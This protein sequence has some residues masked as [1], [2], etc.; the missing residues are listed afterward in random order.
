M[1]SRIL[2]YNSGGGIGD[3]LQILPL[4]N[5]LRNEFKNADFYYLCA[6]ENHFNSS[7]K[8]LNRH[9][10]TL[11][12]NIK[13]FGFRWWHFLILKERI[14]KYK[15]NKFDLIIDLQSKIR[16][17]LILK[18]IP[19]K[20]FISSCFNF[21]FSNP[22]LNIKKVNKIND[23]ILLAVNSILNTNCKLIDYDINNIEDKFTIESKKLLPKNNYIGF[24]ISQGNI[25]RKKEW[26][27]NNVVNLCNKL[28]QNN[29]TPVFFIEKK[30]KKLKNKI[31]ELI[32]YSLFPEHESLLSSPA[33]VA[34]LGK[35]LD[36]AITIDNGIMHMLSLSKVPMISL[37]GP[38]DSEKFAP[39]YENSIVLD[40]KKLYNTKNVAAITV[41]DVLE[42]AKQHLNFSY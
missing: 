25:Y 20:Y 28:K 23:N 35:R 17:S 8:D 2:L 33:L 6:H 31:Q 12:L 41:E 10:N 3:A 11:N 39:Q 16:N 40:S 42:A 26:S 19:H 22:A 4:I 5:A 29:K 1:I 37:F 21:K 27:L 14:K 7:L 24:S 15:I 30:N 38:T 36:F 34:C 32:P 18:M 13:Y 9:I